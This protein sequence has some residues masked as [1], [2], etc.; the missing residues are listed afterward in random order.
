MNL[1]NVLSII[2][3][4]LFFLLGLF[5]ISSKIKKSISSRLMGIFFIFLGLNFLDGIVMLSGYFLD[6]QYLAFW[7]E[8]FV[9]LYGPIIYFYS[10]SITSENFKFTAKRL[11]HAIPFLVL[12]LF[13]LFQYH[14]LPNSDKASILHSIVEFKQPIEILFPIIII[15]IHIS[16]Y[17]LYSKKRIKAYRNDLKSYYS[18]LNIEWLDKSLNFIFILLTISFINS[19]F[20]LLGNKSLFQTGLL[21][22]IVFVLVFVG[23]VYFQVMEQ[24]MLFGKVKMPKN[25]SDSLD[26]QER[27]SIYAQLKEELEKNHVFLNPELTIEDLSNSLNVS[28]RKISRVINV[29]FEQNFFD[30]VN[31][32]RIEY[33]KNMMKENTDSGQTILEVLYESGFNSKSTFNS[34]FKKKIGIT[35]SEFKKLNS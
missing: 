2:C 34:Q 11:V 12:F 33:A 22:L 16:I 1:I 6:H 23:K 8:P 14:L 19:I 5:L 20:Q 4:S 28:T 18:T 30:L 35:P 21:V 13:I 3:I 31:T 9:F 24:P 32:H 17:F 26:E 27:L 29:S 25:Y 7:E 15:F 10:V